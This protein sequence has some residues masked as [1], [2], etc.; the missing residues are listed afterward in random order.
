MGVGAAALL[1]ATMAAVAL[2]V[3]FGWLALAVG[4][5][6]GRRGVAIGVATATAVAG[7]VLYVAGE[8]VDEIRPWQPLS[9][10]DQALSGGPVGS[11]SHLA[12]LVLPLTGA[13]L[14]A[15]V[16]PLFARRD[17]AVAH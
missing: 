15:L 8:L 6:T 7:Y 11:G 1:A 5:A 4:A 13:V 2:A 3:E 12:A 16:L 14:L 10:F 17:I 9:P